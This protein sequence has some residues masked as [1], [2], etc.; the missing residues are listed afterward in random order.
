MWEYFVG[1]FFLM[2]VGTFLYVIPGGWIRDWFEDKLGAA[3]AA[4][5]KA[6]ETVG[7]EYGKLDRSFRETVVEIPAEVAAARKKRTPKREV[8]TGVGGRRRN[9]R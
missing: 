4:G 7:R 2:F 3:W 9:G 6:G 8:S 1:F 5:Y